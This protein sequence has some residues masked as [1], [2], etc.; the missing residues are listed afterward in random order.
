[1]WRPDA[2]KVHARKAASVSSA[3][4]W[5]ATPLNSSPVVIVLGAVAEGKQ[6]A[7]GSRPGNDL[8]ASRLPKKSSTGAQDLVNS[9]AVSQVAESTWP[10]DGS[11]ARG[12]A[13]TDSLA[14]RIADLTDTTASPYF[15]ANRQN[16]NY[17]LLDSGPNQTVF[18]DFSADTITAGS[19]PDLI[20]ANSSDKITGLTAADWLF[21]LGS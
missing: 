8:L 12:S 3:R 16:G 14:T 5:I 6:P 7:F 20:F 17:F 11:G 10:P 18:N 2:R 4:W 1:V 19:G 9:S 13:P 15:T 21:I